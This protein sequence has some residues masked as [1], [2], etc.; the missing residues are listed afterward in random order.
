MSKFE[1]FDDE[2]QL[3]RR[4]DQ[5]RLDDI[6]D[7]DIT[8]V[9]NDRPDK[10]SIIYYTS[11]NFI[12]SHGTLWDRFASKFGDEDTSDR[13]MDKLDLSGADKAKY[14]KALDDGSILLFV[15]GLSHAEEVEEASEDDTNTAM[16]ESSETAEDT[17]N[18]TDNISD[19]EEKGS[20]EMIVTTEGPTLTKEYDGITVTTEA[21]ENKETP[22]NEI[23]T[24]GDTH[25]IDMSTY[26]TQ[27]DETLDLEEEEI[28]HA[29][30]EE[31]IEEEQEEQEEEEQY[32]TVKDNVVNMSPEADEEG[33]RQG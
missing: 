22:V 30:V 11:V 18:N 10:H 2:Q 7:E 33:I 24:D 1:V 5:L 6:K 23:R 17:E 29:K 32:H 19:D 12:I 15:K 9:A 26:V 14:D 13:V 8:V 31:V 3:S 25:R 28:Q 21:V 20:D 4:I 16:E 27:Y